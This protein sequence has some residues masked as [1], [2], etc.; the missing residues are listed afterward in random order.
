MSR[1]VRFSRNRGKAPTIV[2][3]RVDM[4]SSDND[5]ISASMQVARTFQR[6]FDRGGD[7]TTPAEG[8][9]IAHCTKSQCLVET[10]NASSQSRI[11][12]GGGSS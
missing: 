2:P 7:D 6:R 10:T 11:G 12:L 5:T 8:I 1:W 9:H 4:S 3:F